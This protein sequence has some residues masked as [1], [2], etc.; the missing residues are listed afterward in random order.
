MEWNSSKGKSQDVKLK[1]IPQGFDYL[2]IRIFVD[3]THRIDRIFERLISSI[4][5]LHRLFGIFGDSDRNGIG[6]TPSMLVI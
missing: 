1:S 2:T 6:I 3:Q 5:R 4:R